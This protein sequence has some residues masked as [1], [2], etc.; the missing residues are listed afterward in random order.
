MSRHR[1]FEQRR[2]GGLP[3]AIQSKINCTYRLMSTID[4]VCGMRYLLARSDGVTCNV[5]RHMMVRIMRMGKLLDH[6]GREVR[7]V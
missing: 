5:D 3:P 1:T 7:H 4:R 6:E 2:L